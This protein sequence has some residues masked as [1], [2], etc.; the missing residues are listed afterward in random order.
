MFAE[1]R[2]SRSWRVVAV[3]NDAF[4]NSALRA[5]PGGSFFSL[6]TPLPQTLHCNTDYSPRYAT[7]A[8]ERSFGGRTRRVFG[9]VRRHERTG[10]CDFQRL[11]RA[12][13]RWV[14][15]GRDLARVLY[16]GN[17]KAL[18]SICFTAETDSYMRAYLQR[19]FLLPAPFLSSKYSNLE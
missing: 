10:W 7:F 3:L 9:S 2:S 17:M 5:W 4:N 11:V 13:P 16:S 12:P 15:G 19:S 1:R 6:P 8:A 18:R 14:M